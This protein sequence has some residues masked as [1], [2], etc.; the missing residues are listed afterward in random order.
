[1]AIQKDF[2]QNLRDGPLPKWASSTKDTYTHEPIA[3]ELSEPAFDV[4]KGKLNLSN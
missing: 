3:P 1:M 4:A 2:F